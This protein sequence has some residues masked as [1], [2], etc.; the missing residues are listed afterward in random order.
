MSAVGLSGVHL[1]LTYK[2]L[3]ECD[4]CFVWSSPSS[5]G[6]MTLARLEDII[7]QAHEIPSVE[8]VYFEGGEPFL[9]YPLMLRGIEL[10]RRLSL[11]A[12]V[13][14]NAYFATDDRAADLWLRPLA[15]LGISDLSLSTDSYHGTGEEN[16]MVR[17]AKRAA[18]RLG[19]PVGLIE[20]E[21]VEQLSCSAPK[22]ESKG[23][24]CFRGRAAA[25]LAG[26]VK[27]RPWRAFDTC[28]E[29]PPKIGRVHIDPYGN[30]LFCQGISV[31]N[32][33][34][35]PL[36][37]IMSDLNPEKHPIIGPLIE[38]GPAELAKRFHVTPKRAYADACHMCYEIRC[39]LRTRGAAKEILVPDQLYGV[40]S[41]DSRART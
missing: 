33:W 13:V 34:E 37:R 11:E 15:E 41:E 40:M 2:C 18:Q 24:L 25:E 21:S 4:H 28:P 36:K 31:G 30:V 3:Y 39:A 26:K 10:T 29:E 14:T 32:A 5:K 23:Q 22:D 9:F 6:T 20:I 7:R 35:K 16:K 8:R 1:L 17:R 38:G 27:K 12:G 19:I